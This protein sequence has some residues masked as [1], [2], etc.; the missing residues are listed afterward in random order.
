MVPLDQLEL[1]TSIGVTYQSHTSPEQPH[2]RSFH[3]VPHSKSGSWAIWATH[4][5]TTQVLGGCRL[6]HF[7]NRF[8][9]SLLCNIQSFRAIYDVV[10]EMCLRGLF[11]SPEIRQCSVNRSWTS[12]SVGSVLVARGSVYP[13][14][15]WYLIWLLDGRVAHHNT[16]NMMY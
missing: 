7:T 6:S 16:E 4:T 14:L 13:H 5:S 9:W 2:P 1:V 15:Q 10:V 8:Q 3:L 12:P 11:K